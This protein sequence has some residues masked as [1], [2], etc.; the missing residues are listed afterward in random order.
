VSSS[1]SLLSRTVWLSHAYFHPDES[2]V[3]WM[4]LDAVRHPS[5]PDHGLVSSYQA[6]QPPGLVWVTGA[7]RS[8]CD[9]RPDVVIVGF[10]LLNATAIAFLALTVARSWSLVQA[11]VDVSVFRCWPGRVHVHLDLA[12][13]PLLGR[14]QPADRGRDPAPSGSRWWAA[15]S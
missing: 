4:A 1:A 15:S 10:G 3:L 11:A 8:A 5:L 12:S 2:T 7:V 14:D 6:F 13:K 9:G